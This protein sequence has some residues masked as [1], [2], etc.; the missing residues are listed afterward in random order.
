LKPVFFLS[1]Q[2]WGEPWGPR[3]CQYLTTI[4]AEPTGQEL[5][6]VRVFPAL[7]KDLVETDRDINMLLLGT[8]SNNWKLEN[9]GQFGFM[10]DI[11]IPTV[12]PYGTSVNVKNLIRIGIG[13]IHK[14]LQ[15]AELN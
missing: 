8:I 10:V 3:R 5:F 13:K 15:D 4:K 11:F 14:T 9:I 6:Y 1:S 7:P 2:D 12:K